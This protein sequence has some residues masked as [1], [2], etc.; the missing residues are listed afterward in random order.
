MGLPTAPSGPVGTFQAAIKPDLR[1]DKRKLRVSKRLQ[2]PKAR[3][4]LP[5]ISTHRGFG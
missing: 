1:G 4:N 2:T 5:K 3:S